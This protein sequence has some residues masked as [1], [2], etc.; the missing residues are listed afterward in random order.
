VK[1][2]CTQFNGKA[3]DRTEQ[4]PKQKEIEPVGYVI[5]DY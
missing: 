4:Q 5:V 3:K 2:R 1:G